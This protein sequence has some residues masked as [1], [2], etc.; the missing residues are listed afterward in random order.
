M[1]GA[2]RPCLGEGR[3]DRGAR[4][5]RR[6]DARRAQSQFAS[7]RTRATAEGDQCRRRRGAGRRHGIGS[8][9]GAG[10]GGGKRLQDRAQILHA[11]RQARGS[12]QSQAERPLCGGSEDHGA[13]A[14]VRTA[15]RR[16]LSARR[17]RDRQSAAGV[18]GG[19]RHARLDRRCA[20][21]GEF[22][23]PRRPL[24]RGLRAQERRSV[25]V[26]R[27][28]CGARRFAR[29]ICPPAGLRG[30]HVSARPLWPH[31]RPG[32]SRSRRRNENGRNAQGARGGRLCRVAL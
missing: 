3:A 5:R 12:G 18:V 9:G 26:H 1:D 22:R 30:G 32:R 13:A 31:R 19:H 7:G 11:R 27:R 20:G 2:C 15:H 23:V 14:A 17:L 6:E 25:G 28:I 21:A 4:C 8:P 10:T 16:R 24:Q 29:P